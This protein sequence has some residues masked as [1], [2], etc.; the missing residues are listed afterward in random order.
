MQPGGRVAFLCNDVDFLAGRCTT[1]TPF[2]TDDEMACLDPQCP[3][4][5]VDFE[6]RLYHGSCQAAPDCDTLCHRMFSGTWIMTIKA[7]TLEGNISAKAPYCKGDTVQLEANASWGVPPYNYKWLHNGDTNKSTFAV[8]TTDTT[9]ICRIRDSCS[10]ECDTCGIVVYDTVHLVVRDN[11]DISLSATDVTC[12]DGTD[13]SITAQGSGTTSPYSYE[14]NTE[15]PKYTKTLD[16]IPAGKYKVTVTDLH[17][18]D[19]ED[20]LEVGYINL[21]D[22][23]V[24]V[25]SVSCFGARDGRI[26]VDVTGTPPYIYRWSTGDTTAVLDSIGSGDYRITVTDDKGCTRADTI[27][28]GQPDSIGLAVSN[29][30][31]II[32]GE[33]AQIWATVSGNGQYLYVW[34]PAADL[35]DPA[36]PNP[37]ATPDTSTMYTVSVASLDQPDCH[38]IDSVLVEVL[39]REKLFVPTAFTPNNDGINDIFVPKG[40]GE[41]LSLRIYDRWGNLVYEGTEGWNGKVGGVRQPI[42]TYVYVVEYRMVRGGEI[43]IEKGNLTLIR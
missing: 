30:Q 16:S 27:K 3:P 32:A 15:P 20:S 39:R 23:T 28:L 19:T 21:L 24:Q 5:Q 9:F 40:Q 17:G 4:H 37:I 26:A 35:N 29:D 43:K 7:R 10:L 41:L 1:Q 13:G 12:P 11:P 14:W 6:L 2:V 22:I 18:C 25:D 33:Q 8:P 31:V 34:M 42:G 38:A 36:L